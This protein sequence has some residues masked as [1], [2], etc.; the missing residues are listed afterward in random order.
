MI[1]YFSPAR[2]KV[3]CQVIYGHAFGIITAV[4]NF[5][6]LPRLMC[7]A[8]GNLL[9]ILLNNYVD[10]F[11]NVD[12]LAARGATQGLLDRF[13]GSVGVN[14]AR[15]KKRKVNA[16]CNDLL[17][18]HIDMRAACAGYIEFAPQVA[19]ANAVLGRLRDARARDNIPPALAGKIRAQLRWVTMPLFGN[20]GRAAMWPLYQREHIDTAVAAGRWP[21]TTQMQAMLEYLTG[22]LT[23]EGIPA[24]QVSLDEEDEMPVLLY[25]DASEEATVIR[26]GIYA[27]DP[28]TGREVCAKHRMRR[29]EYRLFS[30]DKEKRILQGE[31]LAGIA[32]YFTLPEMLRGRKVI[33]F[34]DNTGA[35]SAL[36]T[37]GPRQEDNS[38]LVGAYH[39]FLIGLR[40]RSEFVWVPSDANI[41]DWP[42]RPDKFNM[43]PKQAE[44][45]PMVVPTEADIVAGSASWAERGRNA[46]GLP[47]RR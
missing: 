29:D 35:L 2:N 44:W 1:T 28:H 37:G 42:T 10:D 12:F 13:F 31:V 7:R 30:P 38:R 45:I 23:G 20:V 41:A 24:A 17:G 22:I 39:A 26:L 18:V 19:K 40:T 11:A 5:A 15:A 9:M 33:H 47:Y 43:I 27:Y 14:F 4:I 8:T 46:Y 36:V 16:V 32:A 25:T 21:W 3:V 34:I 6:H